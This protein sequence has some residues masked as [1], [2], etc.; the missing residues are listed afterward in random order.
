M[1]MQILRVVQIPQS[2]TLA[3]TS[4]TSTA[5]LISLVG[6]FL[7]F[8][9]ELFLLCLLI[10]LFLFFLSLSSSLCFLCL[11]LLTLLWSSPRW[12]K[13]KW[14]RRT[15]SGQSKRQSE[16]RDPTE[17]S[18]P[19]MDHSRDP[20]APELLHPSPPTNTPFPIPVRISVDAEQDNT[21]EQLKLLC[22]EQFSP[23]RTHPSF[24]QSAEK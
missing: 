21:V 22:K 6:R 24:S 9:H 3:H 13:P 14:M 20:G 17:C 5:F 11:H 16:G 23:W 8:L 18:R 1:T 10:F 2:Q 15:N 4:C 19:G 12:Q 7:Y